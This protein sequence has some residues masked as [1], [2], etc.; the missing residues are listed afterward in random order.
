MRGHYYVIAKPESGAQWP[1]QYVKWSSNK[2]TYQFRLQDSF[3]KLIEPESQDPRFNRGARTIQR[4]YGGSYKK[5]K[6]RLAEYIA[7]KEALRAVGR[8]DEAWKEYDKMFRK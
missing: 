3:T 6:Q 8:E 2:T 4:E 1:R 5:S 7:K